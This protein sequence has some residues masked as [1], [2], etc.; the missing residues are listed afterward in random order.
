M[1]LRAGAAF[2]R[3]PCGI[4]P[5]VRSSEAIRR[6]PDA[7]RSSIQDMQIHHRRRDG[8]VAEQFLD[9]ADVVAILPEMRGK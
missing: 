5:D 3:E 6:A 8:G 9:R 4:K 2:T 1:L 7:E